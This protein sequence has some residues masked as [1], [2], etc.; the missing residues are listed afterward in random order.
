MWELKLGQKLSQLRRENI[1][2]PFLSEENKEKMKGRIITDIWK[3]F[4]TGRKRRKKGIREKEKKNERIIKDKI[5]RD[6]RT[7]FEQE[8]DY[9]KP[10]RVSSFWNSNYIGYESNGDKKTQ[11]ITRRMS[12]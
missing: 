9:Y 7:P 12:W 6:I 2:K 11:L 1:K 10:K 8:E 5:I 4:E 3:L